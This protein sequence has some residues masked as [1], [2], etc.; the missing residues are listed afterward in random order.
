M[1][2]LATFAILWLLAGLLAAFIVGAG[3]ALGGP[4]DPR[5][6]R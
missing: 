5:R 2:I 6:V 3:A 1:T 4:D